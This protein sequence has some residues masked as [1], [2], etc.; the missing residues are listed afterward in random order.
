ML[1][2]GFFVNFL[3]KIVPD[4]QLRAF[5]GVYVLLSFIGCVMVLFRIFYTGKFTYV[6]LV[7]NLFLAW[8][9]FGLSVLIASIYMN[10][11]KKTVL[12]GLLGIV[13]LFFYPN[14]PYIITDYIHIRSIKFYLYED[15]LF[16]GFNTDFIVW[17]DFVMNSTF[18]IT[19]FLL[20]F[21]SL[22]LLHKVVS[23]RFSKLSGWSFV[24][25]ILLMSSFGIY[26]GRFIRWNSW[27][28]V[29]NPFAL[30]N[31]VLDNM[32]IQSLSFTALLSVFLL[33]IY[34]GLYQLTALNLI[35]MKEHRL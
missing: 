11:N 30:M 2:G 31:S 28:I 5:I 7:W 10:Y 21:V 17:Y 22:F 24:A 27:D 29:S 18:I 25:G 33:L 23:D 14:A 8:I 19:G 32:H 15:G 16:T 3:D 1:I 26:L 4:K 12:I 20:G 34:I 35:K 9:P 6:Y 13:W